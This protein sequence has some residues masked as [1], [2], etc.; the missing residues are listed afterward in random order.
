MQ[1]Q[2]RLHSCDVGSW[3]FSSEFC[4]GTCSWPKKASSLKVMVLPR[5]SPW[6]MTSQWGSITTQLF[7]LLGHHSKGP[8]QLRSFPRDLRIGWGLR[9]GCITA[10][11]PILPNPAPFPPHQ[12][13]H[14]GTSQLTFCTWI[15]V[16]GLLPR[17]TYLGHKTLWGAPWRQGT[18][19]GQFGILQSNYC[20]KYWKLLLKS[21]RSSWF[22]V[23]SNHELLYEALADCGPSSHRSTKKSQSSGWKIKAPWE[24]FHHPHMPGL[25]GFI[26]ITNVTIKQGSFFKI[27][28]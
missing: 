26:T 8:S 12:V 22:I 15:S 4:S 5:D 19:H 20:L 18:S 13:D 6:T 7:T 14:K 17:K 23:K 21:V 11:L 25:P 16:S 2:P 1:W 10:Q 24:M 3:Q 27:H 9:C 28:R